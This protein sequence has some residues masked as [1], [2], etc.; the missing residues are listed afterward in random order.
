MSRDPHTEIER[1]FL[2]RSDAWRGRGESRHIVQGY[3]NTDPARVVRVRL[4]GDSARFT[5][6]GVSDD[7]SRPEIE[8]DIAPD[9][10][11]VILTHPAGFCVGTPI[12]KIRTVLIVGGL[13]WEVDEFFG[14]N[15]GLIIA[16][17]EYDGSVPIEQW[18]AQVDQERPAWVSAEI[19]G[20]AR[21]SNSALAERPFDV[22]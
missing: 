11:R 10:A 20:E 14:R 17:T 7:G 4:D 8:C 21:Y 1:R 18:H 12:D 5:V 9:T 3:L 22:W 15:R 6:K 19:T 2:V 13:T 16:E